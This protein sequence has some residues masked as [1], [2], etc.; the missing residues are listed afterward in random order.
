[1]DVVALKEFCRMEEKSNRQVGTGE[2][3]R[4]NPS[5]LVS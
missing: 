1:M 3:T 2:E 4:R 5:R